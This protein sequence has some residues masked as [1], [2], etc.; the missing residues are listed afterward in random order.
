MLKTPV[1]GYPEAVLPASA[2]RIYLVG[3]MGS[4][5]TSVGI[6]LAR[7]LG[8]AFVDLDEEIETRT[9]MSIPEIFEREGEPRFRALES[10]QLR[11]A[12]GTNRVVV[13]AG[14][15]TLTRMENRILMQG[16]GITVWLEAP[17]EI[18]LERCAGGTHR[19]LLSS[20]GKMRALLME[21]LEG[22]RSCD[23]RVDASAGSPGS[24]SREILARLD[25]IT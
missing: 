24:I 5:K 8:Y 10:E 3:F 19:P 1:R 2:S 14:G 16:S 17:L 9:G 21:R 18:M 20:H 11:L 4:G 15:G 7:E 13:A 6:C 23:L 22:Y 25:S 12:L